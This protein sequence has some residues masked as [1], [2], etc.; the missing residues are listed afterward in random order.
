M[1]AINTIN[2]NT[3]RLSLKKV[4]SRNKIRNAKYSKLKLSVDLIRNI[5]SVFIF[6]AF[7]VRVRLEI[8]LGLASLW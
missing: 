7:F 2:N 6:V 8:A 3:N 5:S 1:T 4:S